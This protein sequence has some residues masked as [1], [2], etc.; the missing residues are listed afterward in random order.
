MVDRGFEA[1]TIYN[2]FDVDAPPGDRAATRGRSRN[3]RP[4]SCWSRTPCGPSPGRT[5]PAQSRIAEAFGATYW[6]L[7]PAEEGYDVELE[8]SSPAHAVRSCTRRAPTGPTSTP[9]PTSIVFPS[10]WE[11]FGNPPIEAAIHRRP[12]VVGDYPVAAELRE[13]GFRWFDP[14]DLD[15]VDSC[16]RH[17]DSELLDHNRDLAVTHLSLARMRDRLSDLLDDAGWLP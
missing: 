5:S 7:G 9:P 1:T 4:T 16:L 6:L 12:V 15:G 14:N 11:G 2:G 3:R 8:R 17:P 13:L 10:T